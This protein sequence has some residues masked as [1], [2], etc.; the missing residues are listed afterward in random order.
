M[1]WINLAAFAAMVAVNFSSFGMA[2]GDVA[3][4][5]GNLFTPAG[6]AFAI[7]GAIY[8]LMAVYIIA[9]LFKESSADKTGNWV[10][11]S[12]LANIAWMVS[13][14]YK[15]ITLSMVFMLILLGSLIIIEKNIGNKTSWYTAGFSLYTG[16]ISVATLANLTVMFVS[17]GMDGYGAAAKVWTAAALLIG[18]GAVCLV[19]VLKDDAV[20]GCAGAIGFLG[21]IYRHLTMNYPLILGCATLGAIAIMWAVAYAVNHKEYITVA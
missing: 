4:S 16:W 1:K 19:T 17:L 9:S 10:W 7:W 6:W 18:A 12:C 20:Y 13:W 11:V 8:A 14:H 15:L 21:I 3:D 2:T 5:Y